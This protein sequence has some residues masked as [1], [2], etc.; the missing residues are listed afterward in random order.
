MNQTSSDKIINP[1]MSYI[2]CQERTKAISGRI[3]EVAKQESYCDNIIQ[4]K[5]IDYQK[6]SLTK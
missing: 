6:K 3:N 2:L 4:K 5:N 1:Y